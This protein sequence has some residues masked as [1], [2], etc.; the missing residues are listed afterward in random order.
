MKGVYIY[1]GPQLSRHTEMGSR[2]TNY[3]W[4]PRRLWILTPN[5]FGTGIPVISLYDTSQI[6]SGY[7]MNK[8][9]KETRVFFHKE[10]TGFCAVC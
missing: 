8:I 5:S 2:A 4:N 6:W 3:F 9:V 10:P 7:I 1:V